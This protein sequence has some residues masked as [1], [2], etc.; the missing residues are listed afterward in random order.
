MKS[1]TKSRIVFQ[2][3]F[4]QVLLEDVQTEEGSIIRDYSIIRKRD[5]VM[6]VATNTSGQYAI[7]EEYKYGAQSKLWTFPAGGLKKNENGIDAAKREL[8][9]ETGCM[10][11]IYT[12]LGKVFDY[13]S[14]DRH[15]VHVVRANNVGCV[16]KQTLDSSESIRLKFIDEEDLIRL[17]ARGEFGVTSAIAAYTLSKCSSLI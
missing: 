11:G 1:T 16:T 17:I 8:A 13:P 15:T 4:V 9:E 12:Y 6:I 10:G 14:K 5:V 2:D 3:S 7:I